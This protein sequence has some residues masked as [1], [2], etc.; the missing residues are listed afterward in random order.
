MDVMIVVQEASS[1]ET[2]A[3]IYLLSIF[4]IVLIA[5]IKGA[6]LSMISHIRIRA[7]QIC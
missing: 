3:I 7:S 2:A 5:N 1:V 4:M 6:T